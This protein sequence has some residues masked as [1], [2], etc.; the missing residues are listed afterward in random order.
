MKNIKFI[1]LLLFTMSIMVSCEKEI[2]ELPET[3]DISLSD[4]QKDVLLKRKGHWGGTDNRFYQNTYSSDSPNSYSFEGNSLHINFNKEI[5]ELYLCIR[6]N[7]KQE[8]F[9]DTFS[10]RKN[11]SYSIP[12]TFIKGEEY[13]IEIIRGLEVYYL[14]FTIQ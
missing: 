5:K 6:H 2:V 9:E 8:V 1:S 13:E 4:N 12:L 11:S 10:A 14:I 3:I 7:N